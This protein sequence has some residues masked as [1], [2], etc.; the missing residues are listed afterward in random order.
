MSA[1]MYQPAGF[2]RAPALRRRRG[3]GDAAADY[4]AQ[5]AQYTPG[6]VDYQF[7]MGCANNPTAPACAAEVSSVLSQPFVPVSEQGPIQQAIQS[8]GQLPTVQTISLAPTAAQ[9]APA[10]PIVATQ[11]SSGASS[12]A[13][14][15][16]ATP[17]PPVMVQPANAPSPTDTSQPTPAGFLSATIL[18]IPLWIWGAGAI[19]AYFV[20]G[21]Q[22]GRYGR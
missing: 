5:A 8:G 21:Y 3:F 1:L 16:V 2:R 6:S 18:G 9:L 22:G 7:L 4:R 15:P 17:A 11:G 13:P 12:S 20:F 19:G 10:T 14:A